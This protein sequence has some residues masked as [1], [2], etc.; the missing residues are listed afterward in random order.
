MCTLNVQDWEGGLQVAILGAGLSGLSGALALLQASEGFHRI[1]VFEA[2]EQLPTSRHIVEVSLDA[3][4]AIYTISPELYKRVASLGMPVVKHITHRVDGHTE[5]VE[6]VVESNGGWDIPG[7]PASLLRPHDAKR[8]N[9]DHSPGAPSRKL[10]KSGIGRDPASCNIQ[11]PLLVV[12]GDLLAAFASRLP[13]AALRLSAPVSS[14]REDID[15][16]CLQLSNGDQIRT[17]V[18][19]GCSGGCDAFTKWLGLP[20][21]PHPAT[22]GWYISGETPDRHASGGGHSLH[23]SGQSFEG[24]NPCADPQH[25]QR[26]GRD[27]R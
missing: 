2:S 13:A 10:S 22:L 21:H 11:G 14:L 27:A 25:I 15:S 8:S 18:L 9:P 17:Q 1:E 19:L 12:W 3:L 7:R 26:N 20:P 23:L 5:V 16:V 6:G 4:Y 24:D